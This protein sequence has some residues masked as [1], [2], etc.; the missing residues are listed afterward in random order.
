MKCWDSPLNLGDLVDSVP[1]KKK[2]APIICCVNKMEFLRRLPLFSLIYAGIEFVFIFT[3][4]ILIIL[5]VF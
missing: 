1:I 5:C 2:N 4:F 3:C